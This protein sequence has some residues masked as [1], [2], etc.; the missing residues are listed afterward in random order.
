MAESLFSD[1]DQYAQFIYNVCVVFTNVAGSYI[2]MTTKTFKRWLLLFLTIAKPVIL[3]THDFIVLL[4]LSKDLFKLNLNCD[5][6]MEKVTK[7]RKNEVF[8]VEIGDCGHFLIS[9]LPRSELWPPGGKLDPRGVDQLFAPAF[10]TT[11]CREY[12][13]L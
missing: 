2:T 11:V 5:Y 8:G 12:S 4:G 6:D 13:P 10:F 3:T 7:K 1:S 9:P